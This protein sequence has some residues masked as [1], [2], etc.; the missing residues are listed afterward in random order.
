MQNVYP[1]E[2]VSFKILFCQ[3]S[4][5]TIVYFQPLYLRREHP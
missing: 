1:E 2:H 5:E 3:F 4:E